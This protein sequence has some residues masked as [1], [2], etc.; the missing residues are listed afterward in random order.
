M[1][2]ASGLDADA[3]ASIMSLELAD[4]L[5]AIVGLVRAGVGASAEPTALVTYIHDCPEVDREI[6]PE[7]AFLIEGAFELVAPAWE[8]AGAIDFDR[9]LT[10]LGRWG[11]P[12]ALA[13][14][15]KADF[16]DVA[17]E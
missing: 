17:S 7:D 4:W 10:P 8:A 12:R 14:A 1:R 11:L 3:E 6:D 2:K 13:W 15:W 16:D 5:G 9:R